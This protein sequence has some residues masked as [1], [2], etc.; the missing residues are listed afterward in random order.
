MRNRVPPAQLFDFLWRKYIRHFTHARVAVEALPVRRYNACTF[1]SP[2]L[3][4]VSTEI[5][6][7]CGLFDVIDT[8][9]ATFFFWVREGLASVFAA[10]QYR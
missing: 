5:G 1:L 10:H 2:V 4:G 6:M 7:V 3:Q 9:N 8:D